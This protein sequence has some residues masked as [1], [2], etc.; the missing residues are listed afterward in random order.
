MRFI[1]KLIAWFVWKFIDNCGHK[2]FS[3]YLKYESGDLK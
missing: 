2:N 1:R 3:E